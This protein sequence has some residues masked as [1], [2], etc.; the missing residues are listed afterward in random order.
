[1]LKKTADKPKHLAKPNSD[2][3]NYTISFVYNF[4]DSLAQFIYILIA[5]ETQVTLFHIFKTPHI[6]QDET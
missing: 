2:V 6:C 1:M 5:S 3:E 4:S